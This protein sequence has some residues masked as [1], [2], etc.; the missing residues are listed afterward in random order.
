MD[1]DKTWF[2][3]LLMFRLAFRFISAM[4]IL[5][6]VLFYNAPLLMKLPLPRFTIPGYILLMGAL[7]VYLIMILRKGFFPVKLLFAYFIMALVFELPYAALSGTSLGL[8]LFVLPWY[9]SAVVGFILVLKHVHNSLG[10]A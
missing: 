8:T 10:R 6:I 1:L 7:E 2:S 3:F 5:G 9:L 4:D